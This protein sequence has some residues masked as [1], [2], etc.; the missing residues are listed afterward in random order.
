[1]EPRPPTFQ[2]DSLPSEPPG[3]P[4]IGVQLINNVVTVSSEQQ[5]DLAVFIHVFILPETPL[6]SR[7]PYNLEILSPLG[8][9]RVL[10]IALCQWVPGNPISFGRSLHGGSLLGGIWVAI[11]EFV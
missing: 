5:R 4:C 8:C 1:M 11:E 9:L 3:K 6:P 2:A 7:L 10:F